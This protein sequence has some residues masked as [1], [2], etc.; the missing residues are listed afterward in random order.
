MPTYEYECKEC[1]HIFEKLQ[2]MNS[3]PL[4]ECPKCKKTLRR[5][6]GRGS[7]VIFKGPGFYA[8]D[9]RKPASCPPKAPS[10]CNAC[11]HNAK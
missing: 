11:P 5:L 10:A 1:G 4:K 3:A 7:G 9:Y 8:T 2:P 6:I